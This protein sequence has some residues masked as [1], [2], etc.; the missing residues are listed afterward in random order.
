[1]NPKANF[2]RSGLLNKNKS[3][4]LKRVIWEIPVGGELVR[5]TS[6]NVLLSVWIRADGLTI[7]SSP[8]LT[9]SMRTGKQFS[10]LV[11]QANEK[12]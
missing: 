11:L 8:L 9:I 4:T 7:P 12:L 3:P 6:K 5:L 1:M 2:S 10:L